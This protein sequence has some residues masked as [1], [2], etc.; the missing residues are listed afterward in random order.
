MASTYSE[1]LRDPRW[2][3]RR[4]EIMER[5]EWC[6]QFCFDSKSTLN[7]HHRYYEPGKQPWE[8]P[9]IALVTLCEHCHQQESDDRLRVEADLIK[10]FR[11]SAASNDDMQNFAQVLRTGLPLKEHGFAVLIEYLEIAQIQGPYGEESAHMSKIAAVSWKRK[12]NDR[13]A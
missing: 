6:C 8:Y 4:L 13:K 9:D 12:A 10:A 11:E 5:D 1:K 3:K 2:Q 7:V